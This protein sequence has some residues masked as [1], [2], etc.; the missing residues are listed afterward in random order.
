MRERDAVVFF[1]LITSVFQSDLILL[2]ISHKIVTDYTSPN[3]A[4]TIT[5]LHQHPNQS[6][7]KS[8]EGGYYLKNQPS[9]QNLF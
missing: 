9:L 8:P 1:F 5:S 7:L 3:P 2:A 6:E 4:V